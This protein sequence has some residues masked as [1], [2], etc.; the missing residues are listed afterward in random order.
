MI[1]VF[2]IILKNYK[3]LTI[4]LLL[5][6]HFYTKIEHNNKNSNQKMKFI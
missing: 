5:G 2:K 4:K 6:L 1:L 3:L